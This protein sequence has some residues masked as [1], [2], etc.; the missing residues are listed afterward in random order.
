M[1]EA[2]YPWH[3]LAVIATLAEKASGWLGRTALMKYAY[4]LQ[5]LKEVPLGYRFTLYAYGPFDRDVLDDLAYARALGA[6]KV[7]SAA[8]GYGYDI[9]P[10]SAARSVKA[11]APDFI[12]AHQDA[13]DWV[14]REF[15]QHSPADLELASTIIYVDREAWHSG[16][17]L[18]PGEMVQR[19]RA[20]KPRFPEERISSETEALLNRGLLLSTS[21][22][23]ARA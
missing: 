10:G 3:R 18:T 16:E 12:A 8:S 20:V 23:S 13:I 1:S 2:A 5:T 6:V 7:G 22:D 9:R 17:P 4:F 19:V 14:V 15:G 11:E 21:P